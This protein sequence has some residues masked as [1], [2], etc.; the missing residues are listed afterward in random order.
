MCVEDINRIKKRNKKIK[1]IDVN[2]VSIG[3]CD[4]DTCADVLSKHIDVIATIRELCLCIINSI[5]MYMHD[6]GVCA[7]NNKIKQSKE[8]QLLVAMFLKI[9]AFVIKLIPIEQQICEIQSLKKSELQAKLG[10]YN[11]YELNDCISKRDIEILME[12]LK[13]KASA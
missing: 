8:T 3:R 9:S 6:D 13:N 11:H 7:D 12:F 10:L 5:E 1:N 4:S 2:D